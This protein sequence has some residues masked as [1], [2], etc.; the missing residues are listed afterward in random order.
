MNI[1]AWNIGHSTYE[2]R[3]KKH[4]RIPKELPAALLSLQSDV[5]ILK[6]YV[7]RP[8]PQGHDYL[9]EC[10]RPEFPCMNISDK[11]SSKH[12]GSCRSGARH[13]L[14]GVRRAVHRA[15]RQDL[16]QGF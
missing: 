2:K 8:A 12:A 9:E 5:I 3:D 15:A 14:H 6:E 13:A 10:L 11:Q 1:I 16:G 7:E 4:V